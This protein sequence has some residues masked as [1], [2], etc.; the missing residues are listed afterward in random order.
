M[1]NFENSAGGLDEGFNRK[2]NAIER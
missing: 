1:V 2:I